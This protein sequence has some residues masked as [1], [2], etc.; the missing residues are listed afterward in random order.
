MRGGRGEGGK[1][2]KER[3]IFFAPWRLAKRSLRGGFAE[4]SLRGARNKSSRCL[5]FATGGL[6]CSVRS[7]IAGRSFASLRVLVC[8]GFT[9]ILSWA[10][11]PQ[12][13]LDKDGIFYALCKLLCLSDNSFTCA[14]VGVINL[15]KCVL[16]VS[17]VT[18]VKPSTA[19]FFA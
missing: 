18:A 16:A 1:E 7:S 9:R 2:G 13:L 6:L 5:A 11:P 8:L 12:C 10:L 14:L 15:L 3:G 17:S 4:R 19:A